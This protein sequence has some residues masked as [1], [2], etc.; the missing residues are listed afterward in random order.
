M[1]KFLVILILLL[2]V[3]SVFS[4]APAM[5]S[6]NLPQGTFKQ[7]SNGEIVQY[8]KNG[9]KIGIYKIQ[10]GKLVRIK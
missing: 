3:P 6:Q 2:S 4:V 10:Y 8:D 1:K 9:K 7:K 5:K